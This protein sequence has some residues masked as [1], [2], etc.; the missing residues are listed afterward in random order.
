VLQYNDLELLLDKE[1]MCPTGANVNI[2]EI[3]ELIA[4]KDCE[5]YVGADTNPSRI[6]V[7]MAISIALLK[8]N[9]YAKYF[10][11][12]L[13]PWQ[14]KKPTLQQRL[15]HEVVAACYVANQIREVLPHRKIIVH[16]DINPDI[17]TPSGKFAKQLKNYIV[18]YGFGAAIKPM[19][20]AASCIADKY[21]G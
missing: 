13:K 14:N 7:V 10:Y 8:H 17:R 11:I 6:P 1:W 5:I 4:A 2:K 12:R 21:A 20:W 15:Q 19:S 18:G 9:E 16:A 3:F